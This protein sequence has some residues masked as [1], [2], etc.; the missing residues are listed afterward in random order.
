MPK[1]NRPRDSL[2]RIVLEMRYAKARQEWELIQRGKSTALERALT[3]A[4][5]LNAAR[6]RARAIQ[7]RGR[8]AQ[9]V[10]KGKDGR[11][12]F[13]NTYGRDPRRSKG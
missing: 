13:E 7:R 1:S 11:I 8:P 5:L 4:A 10:V 12:Q 9:L 6:E 3:K 2:E